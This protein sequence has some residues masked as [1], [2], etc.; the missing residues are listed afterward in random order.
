M[1]KKKKKSYSFWNKQTLGKWPVLEVDLYDAS[2]SEMRTTPRNLG[3][4]IMTQ[5]R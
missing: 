2:S 4:T 3:E 5:M 1:N